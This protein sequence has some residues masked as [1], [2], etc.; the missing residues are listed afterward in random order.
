MMARLSAADVTDRFHVAACRP[1][2]RRGLPARSFVSVVLLVVALGACDSSSASSET[3]G[4]QLS[5][6]EVTHIFE[7][8]R[9]PQ[10]L[11]A[12]YWALK[13]S[14]YFDCMERA[15]FAIPVE[16]RSGS[17]AMP[18]TAPLD[19]YPFEAESRDEVLAFGYASPSAPGSDAP[20]RLSQWVSALD[21]AAQEQY[22]LADLG[23][24][25]ARLTIK[26]SNGSI[27][28]YPG[29]G[30][31]Y[32]SLKATWGDPQLYYDL[33]SRSQAML[34]D[35]WTSAQSTDSYLAQVSAWEQC[36]AS[37]GHP[38]ADLSTI[39]DS[40]GSAAVVDWDC[41]Q[42]TALRAARLAALRAVVGRRGS[43]VVALA[44]EVRA[45]VDEVLARADP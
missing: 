43:E 37:N 42:D 28:T 31:E 15:G 26:D 32:D 7:G 9:L 10:H 33:V 6:E 40:A 25:A 12:A 16:A 2:F 35:L 41:R 14:T 36:M 3:N 1:R 29:E 22:A 21:P 17:Q 19:I 27:I 13:N 4:E 5:L 44:D 18:D 39:A 30:C 23:S 24:D 45:Q 11:P 20:D 8:L 34:G 38:D